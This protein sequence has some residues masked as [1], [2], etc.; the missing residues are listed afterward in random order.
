M[1][2]VLYLGGSNTRKKVGF[3]QSL[4]K[5]LAADHGDISAIK[6]ASI[7]L[8]GSYTIW[9][10][11]NEGLSSKILV[12][13]PYAQVFGLI[14][15]ARIPW[16]SSACRC[17]ARSVE[18]IYNGFHIIDVAAEMQARHDDAEL[19]A[20]NMHYAPL[21]FDEITTLLADS[22]DIDAVSSLKPDTCM[23]SDLISAEDFL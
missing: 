21:V 1:T 15:A 6:D 8:S 22:H 3:V 9:H 20:D 13:Y 12:R 10:K 19:Y 17:H 23:D 11:T 16:P 7:M 5:A 14:F 2:N 18:R 4:N